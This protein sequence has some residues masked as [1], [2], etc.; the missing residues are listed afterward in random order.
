MIFANGCFQMR[1]DCQ[2]F[3][4]MSS[5]FADP[6]ITNIYDTSGTV[7]IGVLSEVLI[8]SKCRDYDLPS[9]MKII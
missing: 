6:I 7:N 3:C 1:Y 8:L 9:T 2:S 4:V 5:E